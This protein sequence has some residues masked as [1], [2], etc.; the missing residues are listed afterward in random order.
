MHTEEFLEECGLSGSLRLAV[1]DPHAA[2]GPGAWE[3]HQPFAVIGREA[4]ADVVL[5]R[6]DVSRCHAYLQAIGGRVFCVD[7][8]SR[9]GI[10]WEEGRRPWGWVDPGEAVRIGPARIR[11]GG[12]ASGRP[13]QGSVVDALPISRA[14]GLFTGDEAVLRLLDSDVRPSAWRISRSLVLVGRSPS[15]K[16]QVPGPGCADVHAGLVRTR[17]GLWIVDLLGPGGTRV[18]GVPVRCARLGDGD[19]LLLG[20]HRFVVYRGASASRIVAAM[21]AQRPRRDPG[22]AVPPVSGAAP[23]GPFEQASATPAPLVESE[24]SLV[25]ELLREMSRQQAENTEQF[26]KVVVMLYQMHQ[27][28]MTLVNGE[29]ERL[30]RLVDERTALPPSPGAG[31]SPRTPAALERSPSSSSTLPVP[32]PFHDVPTLPDLADAC[33]AAGE[34]PQG[35]VHLLIARRVSTAQT[36][37]RG[38]LNRLFGGIARG[39]R[40]PR[41]R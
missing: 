9:T 24:N 10:H 21:A 12:S 13:A 26:Q 14:F 35:D 31:S 32:S 20:S 22:F 23:E 1:D 18:N 28:Q 27:D 36:E 7:L 15:C 5:G 39:R 37:G 19:E 11:P 8:H 6:A 2:V 33:L 40:R 30:R 4:P 17:G 41:K 25:V 34:D 16:V 3:L 29:L 38:R